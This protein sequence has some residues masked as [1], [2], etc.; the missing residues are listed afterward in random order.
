MKQKR[1]SLYNI[2]LKGICGLLILCLGMNLN[3]QKTYAHGSAGIKN[4][5]LGGI[6]IDIYSD[7]YST[8]SHYPWGQYAYGEA[9]CAWF[10]SSR[11]QQLTGQ[12]STIFGGQSWWDT[13]YSNY[14]F[15]RGY[16][17]AAPALACWSNHV[18]VVE[19]LEGNTAYISE[20]GAGFRSDWDHDYT[21]I[22]TV[23]ASSYSS[24]SGHGDFLGFVYLPGGAWYSGMTPV[25]IG[26]NIYSPIIKNDGWVNLADVNGNVEVGNKTDGS[27]MWR[28]ERQAD[29]S[30]FIYNCKTGNVL[31]I[32]DDGSGS[33][34]NVRTNPYNGNP[35][36]QW[37]IYGK[38]N[39]EYYLRSKYCDRALDI[40]G[41]YSTD[42]TNVQLY[43]YNGGV[44][45]KLAFWPTDPVGASTLNVAVGTSV[46][47]TKLSWSPADR[48][49]HY[50]IRIQSGTAG[51]VK[52]YKDIWRYTDTSYEIVLPAGYYEVYVDSCNTFSF[53]A[54]NK[55]SFTVK[56]GQHSYKAETTP[57]SC[58]EAGKNVYTCSVCGDTYTEEIPPAGHKWDDG[59]VTTEATS[60]TNGVKTYTCQSCKA[61]KTEAI[62]AK[63]EG[64]TSTPDVPQTTPTPEVP[65]KTPTPEESDW[66]Y[67]EVLPPEIT[68]EEYTIEYKNYYEKIQTTSPGADW[69]DDGVA[70]TEWQNSG[71]PYISHTDLTTSDATVLVSSIFYHFCGPNTGGYSSS[72]QTGDYVHY[73]WISASSVTESYAGNDGE[74]PYYHL[75]GSDGSLLYCQS[76]VTC[77]GTSGAHGARG[78]TWYKENTYQNRVK[79][80][81]NKYTKESEWTD[82]EDSSATR[83]SYRYR[84]KHTHSYAPE[85]T[86]EA[87]CKEEGVITYTCPSCG[88]SYTEAIPKKTEHTWNEGIV[89]KPASCTK[90]GAKTY[91]CDICGETREEPIEATGHIGDTE[92]RGQKDATCLEEGYTGDIYCTTCGEKL[93]TGSVIEK[94]DHSWDD[95]VVTQEP[96]ATTA[97]VKTYTCQVCQTTKTEEIPAGTEIPAP[98]P[99]TTP[100]PTPPDASQTTPETP[101]QPETDTT[102]QTPT[103]SE[104]GSASQNTPPSTNSVTSVQK[105]LPVGTVLKSI[106]GGNYRVTGTD[107]VEFSK[108]AGKKSTVNI[109]SQITVNGNFYRV[110]SIAPNAFK[111][112]KKLRKVIIGSEIQRIGANA[113]CGCK[114]LKNIRINTKK[115]KKNHVG[116]KAFSGINKKA[117]FKIGFKSKVKT[118]KKIFKSKGAPSTA[119]YRF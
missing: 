96:T 41:G 47:A 68:A 3:I 50:S 109:P 91:T 33:P 18:A 26:T 66:H 59:V 67:S 17:I 61:Q 39:G 116:K 19:K 25:D 49:T 85:I 2:L 74:Y 40:F 93:S 45:Q 58:T 29:G 84:K 95:G 97:G 83:V 65:E 92:T 21:C 87:S 24:E 31:D 9:G 86:K 100:T 34:I 104:T 69:T 1:I 114:N 115:L 38:W 72:D 71:E 103:T 6:Y 70:K 57:A 42:G 36:Q 20:G 76:G 62:P 56:E 53:K 4:N 113:F 106:S 8:F 98:T 14:G 79:V 108:P 46:H 13:Q 44:A 82:K 48:A 11:V 5:G 119:K 99:E 15:T 64:S 89:S 10:A 102:Q 16:T 77:D 27:D 118:Y 51:N 12:G 111:N 81:W 60:T 75:Y 112:N 73:D 54:S 28:F 37:F 110:T 43:E 88:D 30:Y 107:S 22:R 78:N 117:V 80:T 55:V 23:D 52:T 63:G 7:P 105:Q 94:S 90:E 32:W 35:N 101:T